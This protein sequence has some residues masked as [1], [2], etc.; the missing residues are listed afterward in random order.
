M[1]AQIISG[2]DIAEEIRA[3]LK[4]RVARVKEASGI[5]PGLATVLVGDDPASQMYVGMKNKAAAAMGIHSRQITLPADTPQD[6]LLGVVEGLNADPEIHGILVQ[7]PLPDHIDDG[8]VIE[9]IDPA[10]DVDGFHPVNVGRLATDS[11]DF[12]APCTPAGVIEMLMRSGHDPNGKHV[13][14]VG[15]SN[16]VGRPLASLLMRK[17]PGGNA[18][19]TVAH[20]RT[21]DLAAVTR[22]AEVLVVAMGRPEM[23]TADMVG[24]GAVVIDVGT[25]R[26]EDPSREKGYRVCGDVLFDQ[27]KEKA[28][29]ISPVPGGVGPMTI[30]MLLSNTVASATRRSSPAD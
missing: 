22:G 3:E 17:A 12:F 18:T 2:R 10:K 1:T 7:L 9:A 16:I 14:V 19:V 20:S 13:V 24:E 15:R 5:V 21:R 25:N 6:E 4:E 29:A 27:V 30:T 23:I 11:G 28:S 8:A 26:V